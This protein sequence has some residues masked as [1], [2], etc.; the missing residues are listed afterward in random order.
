M[1]NSRSLDQSEV[2]PSASFMTSIEDRGSQ[3]SIKSPNKANNA[4]LPKAVLYVVILI[5]I[6]G[7]MVGAYSAIGSM[8]SATTLSPSSQPVD[9]E[10][11]GIGIPASNGS[12]ENQ[13][14]EVGTT[15]A[16]ATAT[17]VSTE[18][19]F[20]TSASSSSVNLGQ[21]PQTGG[22]KQSNT[23]SGANNSNSASAGFLE[24]FSNVTLQVAAPA[25][26]MQK[27][28]A[29]AYS[30]GGY[31]AYSYAENSSAL[32]VIRVPAVNYQSAL[33]QIEGLGNV[34]FTSST[35]N[36]VTVQY[37][38]LNATLQSL[39][40][41]QTAL[42]HILNQTTQVNET[43]IVES[44]IQSVDAQINSIE[45]QILETST[46]I[47][48]STITVSMNIAPKPA[49]PPQPLN[50]KVTATP[51]SGRTPLAVTFNAVVTGGSTPYIIN[52]NFGDGTS[53]EAQAV[54]H[55][56]T[57]GGSY[58]VTVTATDALGNVTSKYVIITV[59][60]VPL[61]NQFSAFST[62][63]AALFFG[64]LEGIAEVAVVVLPLAAVA[65]IIIIPIRNRSRISGN[66]KAETPTSNEG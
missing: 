61:Q 48:Y 64:V 29:V 66:K 13:I 51:L 47:D 1:R 7:A 45:S 19:M 39:L 50:M 24:F 30:L 59:S 49:P 38:D 8:K 9:G 56:F 60:S 46:L 52:Y 17:A 43:L 16:T 26:T 4:K 33:A 53:A 40:T 41:E 36:D 55:T 23:Q 22:T 37:T 27:V 63:I 32:A 58:N 11:Y 65:V 21:N 35:S 42:L 34:T 18:T 28:S 5:I 20:M 62:T 54:I 6:A 31:V 44:Q 2:T 10:E 14:I 25:S 15:V 12:A 3:L 57:S